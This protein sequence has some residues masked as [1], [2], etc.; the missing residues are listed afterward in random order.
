[1]NDDF[2]Y[3]EDHL[4]LRLE[5]EQ[6]FEFLASPAPTV[7]ADLPLGTPHKLGVVL[8]RYTPFFAEPLLIPENS[9]REVPGSSEWETTG[10]VRGNYNSGGRPVPYRL[11]ISTQEMKWVYD[12]TAPLQPPFGELLH[13]GQPA[14]VT[15]AKED[16]YESG[17]L[18]EAQILY[19][20][21]EKGIGSLKA[22]LQ[23]A[24]GPSVITSLFLLISAAVTGVAL[25]QVA[26]N[27]RV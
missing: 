15:L 5:P 27:R 13:T 21:R 18:R 10:V 11:V 9:W 12:P 19:A 26:R 4:D 8:A 24:G 1:M 14:I 23:D 16:K 2:K 20:G 22:G 6:G 7:S 17:S 3:N 25:G